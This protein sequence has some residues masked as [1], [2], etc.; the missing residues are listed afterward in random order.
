MQMPDQPV[1]HGSEQWRADISKARYQTQLDWSLESF[2]ALIQ[3][4]LAA[5]RGVVLINGGAAVA[6]LAF[7]GNIWSKDP[8][9][10]AAAIALAG[11]LKLFLSGVGMG[12][13]SAGA[14]YLQTCF[15]HYRNKIGIPFQVFG[16]ALVA[17]GLT[18]FIVGSLNAAAVFAH[19]FG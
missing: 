17:G 7:L 9:S 1:D 11:P 14:A 6:I 3:F 2:K 4:A 13:A 8:A 16:I 5:I 18:T 10:H 15:S 19:S 12:V